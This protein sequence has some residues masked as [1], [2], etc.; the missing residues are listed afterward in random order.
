MDALAALR[1]RLHKTAV[2]ETCGTCL[3]RNAHVVGCPE[4]TEE[5]HEAVQQTAHA[6]CREN[7]CGYCKMLNE[8]L[9]WDG[10]PETDDRY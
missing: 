8:G 9:A 4:E 1:A 2:E 7:P 5:E 6:D 10:E 3:V